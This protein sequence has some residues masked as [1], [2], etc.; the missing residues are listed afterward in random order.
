MFSPFLTKMVPPNFKQNV[1][2]N[3]NL[4]IEEGETN[5][6]AGMTTERKLIF[7]NAIRRVHILFWV[8]G[9]QAT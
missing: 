4:A 5:G 7:L 9:C 6:S 3:A 2:E 1:K 8:S